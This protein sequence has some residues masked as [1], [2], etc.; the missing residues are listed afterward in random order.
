M[1]CCRLGQTLIH[2]RDRL[3]VRCPS[4][5]ATHDLETEIFLHLLARH[6]GA[7]GAVPPD[8]YSAAA[9]AH[10]LEGDGMALPQ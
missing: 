2:V 7:L 10:A 5:L 3:G 9:V 6:S 4:N 1:N 8:A